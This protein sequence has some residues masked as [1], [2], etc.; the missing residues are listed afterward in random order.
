MHGLD[1][2]HQGTYHFF[3]S[4]VTHTS[5]GTLL[6][7]DF[8]TAVSYPPSQ[9]STTAKQGRP[10]RRPRCFLPGRW[11]SRFSPSRRCDWQ[12]HPDQST[13]EGSAWTSTHL[14]C[15]LWTHGWLRKESRRSRPC[16][17]VTRWLRILLT[18]AQSPYVCSCPCHLEFTTMTTKRLKGVR[19]LAAR[20]DLIAWYI[21]PA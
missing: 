2:W 5:P 9:G 8:Q 3:S 13:R 15:R 21:L 10:S 12:T 16:G 11:P 7:L 17:R 20:V 6:L 14:L 4:H 18:S 19:T 1:A